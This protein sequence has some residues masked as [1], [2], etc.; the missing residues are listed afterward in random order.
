MD[1]NFLR[2]EVKEIIV[3]LF[4]GVFLVIILPI[5]GGFIL[6]GFE[7]SFRKGAIEFSTYLGSFLIYFFLML[8]SLTLII[9]SI[10]RLVTIER[11]IHPAT[12]KNPSWSTLFSVS[13]IHS[14]EENGALFRL[15]NYFGIPP[16]K[17]PMRWSM[18]ILRITI[19]S[20][21]VFSFYG[22]MQVSYPSLNVAGVPQS[23]LQQLSTTS[24]IIFG[25]GVPSFAENGVLLFIFFF[26]LGVDAYV[27]SRYRLGLGAFFTIGFL[28]I[29]APCALFWASFHNL[30]YGNND[31]AWHFFN[32][33][34]IKITKLVEAKEDIKF[35]AWAIWG[36]LLVIYLGTE[37]YLWKRRKRKA[38]R[39]IIP[40]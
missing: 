25:A 27:C 11:N 39:I 28:L 2:Q 1:N 21:L 35:L 12:Q 15:F 36:L 6:K 10:G 8:G 37:Y 38:E 24:D 14:P 34:F 3:Y 16:E 31:V 29:I 9:F 40:K 32:N 17:N 4:I 33:L 5:F 18:S 13:L 30:V 26:L 22:I 23:S 19:I 7:E 20:I